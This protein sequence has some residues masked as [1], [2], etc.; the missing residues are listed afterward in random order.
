MEHRVRP[1]GELKVCDV[2]L[3]VYKD[4]PDISNPRWRLKTC[5]ALGVRPVALIGIGSG[6]E[7]QIFPA[8]TDIEYEVGTQWPAWQ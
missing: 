7:A 3:P 8:A 5:C 2:D 4:G 1:Y 6:S